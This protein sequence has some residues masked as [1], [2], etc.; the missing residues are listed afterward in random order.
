MTERTPQDKM[1]DRMSR[2]AQKHGGRPRGLSY[3]EKIALRDGLKEDK[4]DALRSLISGGKP[5][6]SVTASIGKVRRLRRRRR[7]K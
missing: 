6:N 1:Q 2:M 3:A 5:T 7:S 4:R